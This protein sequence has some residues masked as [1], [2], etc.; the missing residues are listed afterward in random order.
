M[1]IILTDKQNLSQYIYVKNDVLTST[2]KN[3]NTYIKRRIRKINYYDLSKYVSMTYLV[4]GNFILNQRH[5]CQVIHI[6]TL[7]LFI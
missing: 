7:Y 3:N 5:F 1:P 6:Y 4:A 2:P